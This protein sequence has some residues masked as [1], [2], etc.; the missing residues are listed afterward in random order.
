MPPICSNVAM[1]QEIF[2]K[3]LAVCTKN[4]RSADYAVIAL[5]LFSNCAIDVI[6]F[7]T[8]LIGLNERA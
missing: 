1:Q 3:L 5:R 7:K 4:T 6:Y 2:N 8:R